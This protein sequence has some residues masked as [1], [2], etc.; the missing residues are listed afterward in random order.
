MNEFSQTEI[1]TAELLS[2]AIARYLNILKKPAQ[3]AHDELRLFRHTRWIQS[4]I[5]TLLKNKSARVICAEWSF[6][7]DEIIQK[8]WDLSPCKEHSIAVFALGKLGARELNLSS[9]IDIVFVSQNEPT[10]VEFAAVRNF[11]SI[12]TSSTEF[13]FCFRVDTDLKPGGPLAPLIS[14][15]KQYEDYYW[16]Y[17]ATW[18]R[19]A[20]VRLREI[21]GNS[22]T[23]NALKEI[24]NKFVY[25]RFTDFTFLDDLKKLRS[26]I[27]FHNSEKKDEVHLKLSSGGIRDIEL[28]IHA[29]Q[30]IHGGKEPA[31]R[32]QNTTMAT[33]SLIKFKR[34]NEEE[35]TSLINSYWYY[36]ELEN[37]IQA[38]NDSQTYSWTEANG[39]NEL[40]EFR[41][42]AAKVVATVES[43][44][45]KSLVQPLLPESEDEINSWLQ[46][47]KYS[48]YSIKSK[49]PE[50]LALTAISTRTFADEDLRKRVLRIFIETLSSV[51]LD[52]DLGISLL[53]DFFRS[54]RAK[55]GF[56]S[57]LLHETRL[58][59]E[60]CFLFGCSPYLG[61]ILNSRPELLDSYIYRA[62]PAKILENRID[63]E[64]FYDDLVEK[65]LLNKIIYANQFLQKKEITEL[66]HEMSLNADE[67][68]LSLLYNM[69]IQ[70]AGTP[71]DILALGKW[72]SREL[73]LHSDLD[74]I[75]VTETPPTE[76]DFKF[77]R[78][79]LSRLTEA[80]KGGSL[81]EIDFR[82][83]PSGKAGPVIVCLHD[84][85]EYIKQTNEPWERQSYLR[86]RSIKNNH[87]A[88]NI[89]RD[90]CI[91][92]GLS[93]QDLYSL[94]DIKI[95][96]QHPS[97][98]DRLELKSDAGGLL[99]IELA[100][101]TEI[102]F[103]QLKLSASS[104][105]EIII[106]LGKNK[107]TEISWK[108][109][110]AKLSEN[111]LFLRFIE[112]LNH[113]VSQHPAAYVSTAE[114][115]VTRIAKLLN[116]STEVL[117]KKIRNT[118]FENQLILKT[119]DRRQPQK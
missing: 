51:A 96:I 62:Q 76:V 58:I 74:F 93:N 15:L 60:L 110:S 92:N 85:I 2:P 119:V 64:Q 88:D 52:R 86:A 50:L 24:V 38:I 49:I 20:L 78:R 37:Y 27:R 45:G 1:A 116:L 99:D 12:L 13:G 48:D 68:C 54:T 72:G 80:H 102:L 21:A 35:L 23:I 69:L 5:N 31:V 100:V 101:Q 104:T 34:F 3:S 98:N 8:A 97:T 66:T 4:S 82:L 112:Q 70:H 109:S 83:R 57:L 106:E 111:Y 9:D 7:A 95:K 61:G 40:F 79:F 90:A 113:L 16:T 89:I 94:N 117:I 73:G 114:V 26:Q 43:L 77:A 36:R 91:L 84:L 32:T 63:S 19:L 107:L 115:E 44:L 87:I 108:E 41:V 29:L 6:A 71:I 25:R 39:K 28:F 18:E 67:I 105:S 53:Y 55:A 11:I 103:S 46:D 22:Q 17:G 56:F 65:K 10:P 33:E 14:S 30:V 59:K 47:L 118:L 81:F 75:F 42:R